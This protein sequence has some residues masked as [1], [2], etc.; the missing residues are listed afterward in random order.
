MRGQ[1]RK[2]G[3]AS[4]GPGINSVNLLPPWLFA[5]TPPAQLIPPPEP[6]SPLP[7]PPAG[8]NRTQY[9]ASFPDALFIP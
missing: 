4:S 2:G 1:K 5:R 6:R 9:L 8:S 3:V 7:L